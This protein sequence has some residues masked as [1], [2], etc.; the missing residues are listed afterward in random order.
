[1]AA[2]FRR[3]PRARSRA[4]I[5]RRDAR[6]IAVAERPNPIRQLAAPPCRD[7]EIEHVAASRGPSDPWHGAEREN[8]DA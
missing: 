5:R 8:G 7:D 1:M 3:P 6:A 4:L 2:D